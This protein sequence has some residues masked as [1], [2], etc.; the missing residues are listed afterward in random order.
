MI[1]LVVFITD[2]D[3]KKALQEGKKFS[4]LSATEVMTANPITIE[5]NCLVIDA[6][7]LMKINNISHLPVL[8]NKK[9]IG[10]IHIHDILNEGLI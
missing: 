5:S 4:G 1:L 7:D 3:L 6:L 2:S 8:N 10:I 9:Y